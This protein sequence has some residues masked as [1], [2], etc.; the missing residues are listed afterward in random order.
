MDG[1]RGEVVVGSVVVAGGR[2]VRDV[3]PGTGDCDAGWEGDFAFCA[4]PV[5]LLVEV[6]ELEDGLEEDEGEVSAGA[7]AGED[8]VVW[9]DG[10]VERAGWWVEEGEVGD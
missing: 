7:V 1:A 5:D 8:Y 6:T 4:V 10:R 9:G 2:G 3:A